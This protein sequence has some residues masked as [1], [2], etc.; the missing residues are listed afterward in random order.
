MGYAGLL[1]VRVARESERRASLWDLYT[2]MKAQC[3]A[4]AADNA[5]LKQSSEKE[6][7]ELREGFIKEKEELEKGTSQKLSDLGSRVAELTSTVE[8][9][10]K[11][12]S[13]S[14]AILAK[15][16]EEKAQ[17]EAE[18]ASLKKPSEEKKKMK[19]LKRKLKDLEK[20]Y[21]DL[22]KDY[23][24]LAVKKRESDDMTKLGF[25]DGFCLARHQILQKFPD[26][27][28][29]FLEGMNIPKEPR[30]TWSKIEHLKLPPS[31]PAPK[32][33][34]KST[35]AGSSQDAEVP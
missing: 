20:D 8:A 22:E 31:L 5:Q 34:D 33:A 27:D 13:E 16:L 19:A 23:A 35:E 12:K 3:S 14:D 4:L 6:I 17:L 29:S 26:F 32:A 30:W 24:D 11:D 7:A 25:Q 9:I 1:R 10:Q 2:K 28:L 21:A 18:V 15:T